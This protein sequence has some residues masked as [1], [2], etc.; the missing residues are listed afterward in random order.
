MTVSCESLEGET[1]RL[2]P[3]YYRLIHPSQLAGPSVLLMGG[4]DS[5]IGERKPGG[6]DGGHLIH[7]ET[8]GDESAACW[9]T[10]SIPGPGVIAYT[11]VE[12]VCFGLSDFPS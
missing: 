11:D 6:P 7:G 2:R 9:S 5:Q 3:T 1:T 12:S 4:S 8:G 10:G